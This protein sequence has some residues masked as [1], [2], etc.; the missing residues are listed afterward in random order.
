VEPLPGRAVRMDGLDK[1]AIDPRR[2]MAALPPLVKA[3]VRAG[4]LFASQA[5][6]DHQFGTTDLFTILPLAS[7]DPRYL[8]HFGSSLAG[9]RGC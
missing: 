4:S 3:Y 6:T 7:A 2:T 8:A 1:A 5:V 9:E